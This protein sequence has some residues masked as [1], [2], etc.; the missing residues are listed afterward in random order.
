MSSAERLP[1]SERVAQALGWFSIGLGAAQ[2]A[3]PNGVARLI[4]ANGNGQST[5]LMRAVGARELASG[6]GILT[7][8]QPVT[9]MWTRVVGD[10]MDLVLLTTALLSPRTRKGRVAL[11]T[12]S[13]AGITAVDVMTGTRLAREARKNGGERHSRPVRA[14]VTINKP[15]EEVYRYWRDFERLPTFMT[16]LQSVVQADAQHSRWA[17]RTPFGNVVEW[18]AE[19]VVD[20]PNERIVWRSVE[21]SEVEN[22]GSVR[23]ADAPGGQGTEVHVELVFTPP[24]GPAAATLTKLFGEHPRQQLRDDLR[25]FKQVLETGEVVVSDASPAGTDTSRLLKQ[26]EATPAAATSGGGTR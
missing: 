17:A 14:A 10:V 7:R 21:G 26:R 3:A 20:E 24:V 6:A 11:A 22:A 1:T 9:W 19:T 13:V 4:G 18:N 16:H 25:R 8:E 15:R 23:F 2:E 5:S 12:L